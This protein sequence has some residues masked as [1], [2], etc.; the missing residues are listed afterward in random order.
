MSL[1]HNGVVYRDDEVRRFLEW[2]GY[3][4][5]GT[6]DSEVLIHLAHAIYSYSSNIEEFAQKYSRALND[7]HPGVVVLLVPQHNMLFIHR[8]NNEFVIR[9]TKDRKIMVFASTKR[10]LR[11]IV[12]KINGMMGLGDSDWEEF[13]TIEYNKVFIINYAGETLEFDESVL[14]EP[15]PAYV[16]YSP[17]VRRGYEVKKCPYKSRKKAKKKCP[18]KDYSKCPYYDVRGICPFRKEEA[19]E[20]AS[21]TCAVRFTVADE[22]AGYCTGDPTTCGLYHNGICLWDN[23]PCEYFSDDVELELQRKKKVKKKKKKRGG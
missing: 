9:Y 20:T 7:L 2:L 23:K 16:Y 17:R 12:Q 15:V 18:Y 13:R 19:E 1:V 14:G 6:C 21:S 11:H 5:Q 22:P 4:F 10:A 3:E 8:T